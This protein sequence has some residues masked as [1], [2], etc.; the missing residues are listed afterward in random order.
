MMLRNRPVQVAKLRLGILAGVLTLSII[1]LGMRNVSASP[2]GSLNQTINS[3]TLSTD[4]KDASNVSVPSPSFSLGATTITTYC[5]TTNGTYG[6]NT[7]RVYVDN[8]GMADDGWTLTVAAT[9]G[10]G[11]KWTAGSDEYDYDDAT[12]S[13]CTN[14]QLSLDPSAA[15]LT[16]ETGTATGVTLGSSDTFVNG[17]SITLLN[18]DASSDNFWRG[19]LTG[20]GLS[21]KIPASTP[22]GSYAL[23]LTQT[24]TNT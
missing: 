4:V 21:Q 14:G 1:G 12:G 7:Q 15:S 2:T 10:S 22:A 9:G 8:P 24:I 11:A 20:I 19:Y 6:S 17:S 23:D 5:Q 16:I 3:S 13:G 18:G